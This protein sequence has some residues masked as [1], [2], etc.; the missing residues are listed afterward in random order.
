LAPIAS[1]GAARNPANALGVADT[2]ENFFAADEE[3]KQ[4][5]ESGD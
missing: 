3:I 1:Q 5:F 2:N 4:L